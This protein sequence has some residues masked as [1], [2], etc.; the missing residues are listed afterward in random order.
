MLTID[1]FIFFEEYSLFVKL[2]KI[3]LHLRALLNFRKSI[4]E[5]MSNIPDFDHNYVLPPH[6][7]NPAL[8]D[9][10][11]S[12]PY[13]CTILELCE[14]FSTSPQ[15]IEILKGL[16]SFR[17]ELTAQGVVNGFQYLDGSFLE[18]IEVSENR[19]PNDID[20][21][22]FALGLSN[23]LQKKL[24]KDFPEICDVKKCKEKYQVDH[25]I[26]DY[27]VAPDITIELVRYWLQL[28]SHNRNGVWKGM[29]R[30]ELNTPDIDQ[31]AL[32]LLEEI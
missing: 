19:P 2:L 29:L 18:N 20:I 21:V 30:L 28:F 15:R 8:N 3:Y 31:E 27:G 25:Y 7:G 5:F 16:L 4:S 9:N 17:A 13:R 10:N 26:V 1:N 32:T 23:E 24:I 6:L 11:N 12:S 22:T 14:R